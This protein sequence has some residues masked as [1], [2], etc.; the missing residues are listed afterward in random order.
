[1]LLHSLGGGAR[2]LPAP[3]SRRQRRTVAVV[4]AAN[5]ASGSY[6][7]SSV[8]PPAKGHHFL[9][10]DDFSKDEL[11]VAG[12]ASRFHCRSLG[13]TDCR[14]IARG[15]TALLVSGAAAG[16]WRWRQR[17]RRL[18]HVLG[19]TRS[20]VGQEWSTI[21]NPAVL[22]CTALQWRCWRR[23]RLSRLA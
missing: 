22:V 18:R 15:A 21:L 9:H 17:P 3:C 7:A 2:A 11:G 13:A 23:R 6:S 16:R 12:A 19:P 5:P 20:L 14:G 8:A 4:A 10:I 1:M